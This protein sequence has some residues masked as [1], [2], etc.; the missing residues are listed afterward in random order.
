MRV[1]HSST[2]CPQ[3]SKTWEPHTELQACQNWSS[4]DPDLNCTSFI[5]FCPIRGCSWGDEWIACDSNLGQTPTK[6]LSLWLYQCPAVPGGNFGNGQ[7]HAMTKR[8][9]WPIGR[10]VARTPHRSS[11]WCDMQKWMKGMIECLD[12]RM[13]QRVSDWVT[14]WLDDW[15][16]D[17]IS[18]SVWAWIQN[19]W[20]QERMKWMND[21]IDKLVTG[22]LSDYLLTE[23]TNQWMSEW[24]S[25]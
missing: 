6:T 25:E 21:W 16:T 3:T 23:W 5:L 4:I 11:R 18:E 20:M 8:N 13:D 22:W 10:S 17:W 12:E 7:W 14:E 24:A 2:S 9:Q 15:L 1:Q 19:D